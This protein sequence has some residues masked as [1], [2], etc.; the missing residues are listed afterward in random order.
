MQ[1]L[2][3]VFS[4]ILALLWA[5][6]PAPAPAQDNPFIIYMVLWRG[7]EDACKGFKETLINSGMQV[8]FIERNAD[9]DT[10]KLPG[11]VQEAR[12]LKPDLVLTWGTSVTLGIAGKLEDAG[13][14]RYITEIP[15]VYMVVADAIGSGI[16]ESFERTGRSNVTGTHNRVPEEININAMRTY[17][18]GFRKLGM[19]YNESEAN[20]VVK[21]DEVR[22]LA[23]E[24][25]FELV[26]IPLD[27]GADGQPT[28]ETVPQKMQALRTEGVDFVYVGSSSFIERNGDG[29]TTAA[30][31][32]GLPLLSPY[33][34]LVTEADALLSVSARYYAI[35]ELAARQARRIL[36]DGEKPGDIPVLAMTHFAFV[37]NME[38]ARRLKLFPPLE[39][40]QIAET[41]H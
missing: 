41:V 23:S 34:R 24:M 5:G 39:L 19:L 32:A 13:N 6:V 29:F 7:C 30:L 40:L 21:V 35:G 10:S 25:G 8:N 17:L 15:V 12:K 26:A 14:P 20:S 27:P 33:E 11:F 37:I 22:A 3:A 31:Q 16:I 38:S 2:K 36:V 1:A 18:P 28:L 9:H 4:L